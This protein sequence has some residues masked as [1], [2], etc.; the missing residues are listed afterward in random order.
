MWEAH[1]SD[2][3]PLHVASPK[4]ETTSLH[5][6][7]NTLRILIKPI[8]THKYFAHTNKAHKNP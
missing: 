7:I 2:R 4:P 6:P 3:K 1:L 5:K 8:K